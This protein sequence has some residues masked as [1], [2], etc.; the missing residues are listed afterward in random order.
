MSQA[1]IPNLTG[2]YDIIFFQDT[3]MGIVKKGTE[4][5]ATLGSDR[6]SEWSEVC[7]KKHWPCLIQSE[8]FILQAATFQD[9]FT[10]QKIFTDSQKS[11]LNFAKGTKR[12]QGI[13][14]FA[15]FNTF[16]SK[17]TLKQALKNWSHFRLVLFSKGRKIQLV[18]F[19]KSI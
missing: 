14:Y 8:D 4:S 13:E 15:S 2:K 10:N 9:N 18:N 1:Q 6:D 12:T 3:I 16:S 5:Y 19:D 11:S 17:Q 7:L